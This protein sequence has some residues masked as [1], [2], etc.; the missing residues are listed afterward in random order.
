M[1]TGS[2]VST[3]Q[4]GEFCSGHWH[5]RPPAPG[6]PPVLL[7]LHHP[8]VQLHRA[9]ARSARCPCQTLA[10]ATPNNNPEAFPSPCRHGEQGIPEMGFTGSFRLASSAALAAAFCRSASFSSSVNSSGSPNFR[11]RS[12]RS[13]SVRAT[14]EAGARPVEGWAVLHGPDLRMVQGRG[15]PLTQV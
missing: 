2:L 6:F 9:W 14:S 1:T 4:D 10:A 5:E 7:G 8:K 13:A 12:R 15:V 3:T 11:R